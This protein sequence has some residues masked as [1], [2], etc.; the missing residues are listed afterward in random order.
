[1]S[2]MLLSSVERLR[3]CV[4]GW[5]SGSSFSISLGGYPSRI[6]LTCLGEYST[7]SYDEP[8]EFALAIAGRMLA[9]CF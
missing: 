2:V 4:K 8:N 5:K 6:N 9:A 1:M 7:D 3:V